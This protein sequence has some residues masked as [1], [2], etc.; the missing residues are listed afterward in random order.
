MPHLIDLM[1]YPRP[2]PGEAA[3][4]HHHDLDHNGDGDDHVRVHRDALPSSALTA[5]AADDALPEAGDLGR[6]GNLLMPPSA[7]ELVEW[8]EATLA[9]DSLVAAVDPTE[10]STDLLTDI[11]TACPATT[12]DNTLESLLVLLRLLHA[13]AAVHPEVHGTRA[14]D[15]PPLLIRVSANPQPNASNTRTRLGRRRP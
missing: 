9:D 14:R 3:D 12:G 4:D 6:A 8:A 11:S 15:A 2:K 13:V 7:L 1:L 10:V 5:A